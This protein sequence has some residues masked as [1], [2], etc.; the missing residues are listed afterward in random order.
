MYEDRNNSIDW[1][2]IFL[3]VVI[4]FLVVLIGI[5]IYST[6]K[7]NNKKDVN[8]TTETVAKSK[9]SSTFTA[10]IEKLKKAGESYFN[11]NKDKIPT[12]DGSTTMVTL[13]ELV[14]NGVIG[15][16]T[17]E[18][19]KTC[20]G[21][22]SYVTAIK[23]GEKVKI[24][25]NLVCG[26]ASSYSLIYMGEN[27]STITEETKTNTSNSGSSSSTTSTKTTTTT[28]SGSSSNCG[29]S[30]GTPSVTVSTNTSAKQEV[31]INDSKS[32]V[33]EEDAP[34]YTAD[35]VTVSFD[36]RGG[37]KIYSSQRVKIGSTAVNPG[38]TSKYG[39]RFIGWYYNGYLYDF[40]TPVRN[41]ITLYAV[42]DTDDYNNDY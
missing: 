41:N 35:M 40:S 1:K 26:S 29:T 4:V 16:L 36:S 20:D 2:G 38:S 32:K 22:S 37:S 13:N 17:D 7:D 18:D 9:I 30:C 10:N 19:G 12:V 39:S 42:Y 23:E 28:N 24:K 27:D 21:E 3:K 5:K 14:N 15:N 6:F 34:V 31:K 8:T 33:V 25:A 11:S